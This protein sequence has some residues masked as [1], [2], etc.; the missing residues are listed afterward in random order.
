MH[1][2]HIFIKLTGFMYY[3]RE[4]FRMNIFPCFHS[5]SVISM[6]NIGHICEE[7]VNN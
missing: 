5:W 7:K 3:K 4:E 2:L 6:Y 1:N